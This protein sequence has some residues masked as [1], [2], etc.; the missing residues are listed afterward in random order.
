MKKILNTVLILAA[1]LLTLEGC[2]NENDFYEVGR[3]EVFL[4]SPTSDTVWI[5]NEQKP[6]SLYSF[7]WES[8]RPYM[9]YN[10]VFSPSADMSTLRVEVPTGIKTT[11]YIP[12]QQ[13]DEI[14]SSMEVGPGERRTIYWSVDVIDPEAGWC[15]DKR[16]LTI[17][18][19][20]NP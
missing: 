13:M 17:T 10:L 20:A 11:F 6:D 12:T 9:Q 19:F 3:Q 15:D 4:K 7:S 1:A 18:R 5:L 8:K 14:L 16:A 2:D